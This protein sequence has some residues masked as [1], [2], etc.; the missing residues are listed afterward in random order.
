MELSTAQQVL[1]IFLS[2]ALG[3]FLILAIV[4]AAMV[5]KLIATIRVIAGKAEHLVE[6]VESVGN[7]FKKAAGPFSIFRFLHGIVDTVQSKSKK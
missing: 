5:I 4:I 1:V 7:I 2:V 3:V 6:S